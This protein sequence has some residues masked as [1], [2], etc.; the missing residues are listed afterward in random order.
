VVQ[1]AITSC[2]CF[3]VTV[4]TR[5]NRQLRL[6]LCSRGALLDPPTD[7]RSERYEDPSS[8]RDIALLLP[9]SQLSRLE[10]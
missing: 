7:A 6:V 8:W 1:Q 2:H 5:D 9:W 3:I 10:V 4:R